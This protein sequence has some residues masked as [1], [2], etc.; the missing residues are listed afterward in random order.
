MFIF[1]NKKKKKR[2]WRASL[3]LENLNLTERLTG[4]N[5]PSSGLNIEYTEK[6][7]PPFPSIH[8]STHS[9]V[10]ASIRPSIHSFVQASICPSIHLSIH[11]SIH[12]NTSSTTL[13]RFKLENV[14]VDLMEMDFPQLNN[15]STISMLTVD[16]LTS[17]LFLH[18][19]CCC[20][21]C[22]CCWCCCCCCCCCWWCCCCC[23]WWC[24]CCCCCC[25]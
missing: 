4:P 14:H 20:F 23:W 6:N 17:S 8:P 22:C 19:C 3:L 10:Q 16:S 12:N 9:F 13:V 18:D 25:C 15:L 1:G 7:S 11:P 2:R 24:C 5:D 21:C